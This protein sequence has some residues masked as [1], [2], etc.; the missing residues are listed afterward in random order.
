LTSRTFSRSPACRDMKITDIMGCTCTVLLLLLA[1]VWVPFVGPFFSLLIPLPFLY[2][3]SRLGLS[4]G[5]KTG[6]IS[7]FIVGLIARLTGYTHIIL[8]CIEFSLL[9][10]IISEIYRREFSFGST[11]FWGTVLML[12][13][14]IF[15]LFMIGLSKGMGPLDLILEY[16][17]SNLGN[18]IR[19]YE[20]I[21]LEPEK[22]I[23]IKQFIQGLSDLIARIYPSL[24]IVGTAF[25]VWVNVVISR[26]L[27]RLKGVGYPD[28]G[29][30]DRWQASE[31][32]V[33]GVIAAG[34]ALFFPISGIRSL[35]INALIVTSVIYVFHGLSI[36][37]F[38]FN[39]HNIP[40]WA[41]L[42]VYVLIVVQQIFLIVLAIAG[43]FDQ[44][45]DFRKIHRKEEG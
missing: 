39:R 20:D 1:S 26:P 43:L 5:V 24:I 22:V 38:F 27:F 16:F 13:V 25:V 35:A 32:M 34:F 41:R 40:G 18:S 37:M 23:Q 3:A 45:V 17:Q 29:P 2:Y 11:I 21:G 6:I 15:F 4:Q 44:W 42:G 30:M 28:F 7:L 19:L 14:G 8:F 36:V 33:W 31:H 10:V 9:G 12:I